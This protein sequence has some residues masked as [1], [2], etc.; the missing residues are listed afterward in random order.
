MTVRP[1]ACEPD[2]RARGDAAAWSRALLDPE[3]PLP[4][5]LRAWNG[6]DPAGR[7]AVYRNNVV[8]SLRAALADT[9]PVA[10]E[11]AGP[12]AFD[13]LAIAWARSNPP[14]SPVLADW[15]GGLA[16]A[17]AAREAAGEAAPAPAL[18][19]LLRLEWARAVAQHAA[20]APRLAAADLVAMGLA[21]A[22]LAASRLRLHPSFTALA[23]PQAAVSIWA[24]HQQDEAERDYA[25]LAG[26]WVTPE[27]AWVLRG[28]DDAVR[29]LPVA[30]AD[31]VWAAALQRGATLAEATEATRAA[32]PR[33]DLA[34][35]LARLIAHDALSA[36]TPGEPA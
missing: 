29:V 34:V 10:R 2:A 4:A 9:Y 5:G 12:V 16:D 30:A 17:L 32:D 15:G 14:A 31:A 18:A 33:F 1:P 6:S 24:L 26:R 23:L 20:D 35:A 7:F 11:W 25:A 3:A 27:S 22:A 8:A 13:A 28:V 19:A 36:W 21:P